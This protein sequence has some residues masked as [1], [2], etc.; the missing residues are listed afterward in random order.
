MRCTKWPEEGIVSR[1]GS[2]AAVRG[3]DT[4]LSQAVKDQGRGIWTGKMAG[5][6]APSAERHLRP[7]RYL[8]PPE[9]D[10]SSPQ[11][12]KYFPFTTDQAIADT[13]AVKKMLFNTQVIR[14]VVPNEF[15][16]LFY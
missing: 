15:T 10:S 9:L 2:L 3:A 13:L 4:M 14:F 1:R 11:L 16:K 12:T 5:I 6:L 8:P 7:I